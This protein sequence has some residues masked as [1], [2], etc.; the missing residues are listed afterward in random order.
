MVS[1]LLLSGAACQMDY[2]YHRATLRTHTQRADIVK[3]HVLVVMAT[4]TRDSR[5]YESKRPINH[6]VM[7]GRNTVVYEQWAE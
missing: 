3:Q 1:L 6:D 7:I 5:M 2:Y 4:F